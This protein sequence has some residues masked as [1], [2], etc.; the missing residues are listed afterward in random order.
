MLMGTYHHSVDAK[1]RMII[2]SKLKEQLGDNVTII[3]DT[4]GCL[5]MYSEEEW[6]SYTARLND[7][8]KSES[9]K[10]ARF[11]YANAVE[12]QPDAQGR[13]LIPDN[14]IEYAGIK[15]N[16]VTLGC[17]KYA[18]VWAE[19]KYGE[20]EVDKEPENYEEMQKLLGM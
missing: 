2:P 12:V 9:K 18:E 15:K 13:I 19:E 10:L 20:L 6:A 1:N 16:I 17:G 4:G 3:K 14:M 11:L 8:P 5:C 7:I